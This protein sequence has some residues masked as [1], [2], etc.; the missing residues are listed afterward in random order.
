MSL[1]NSKRYYPDWN[2]IGCYT[3]LFLLIWIVSLPIYI[4]F[5]HRAPAPGYILVT[6]GDEWSFKYPSDGPYSGKVASTGKLFKQSAINHTWLDYE[7][8]KEF[9]R[10]KS[11]KWKEVN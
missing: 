10:V 7:T 5:H 6:N 4:Y 1:N 8:D 9:E 3:I 11:L 2:K